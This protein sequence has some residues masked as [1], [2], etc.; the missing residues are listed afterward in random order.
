MIQALYYGAAQ[1]GAPDVFAA[2]EPSLPDDGQGALRPIFRDT[3]IARY[4][5]HYEDAGE[6]ETI[7][8]DVLRRAPNFPLARLVQAE[9][10]LIF[11]DLDQSRKILLELEKDHDLPLWMKEETGWMLDYIKP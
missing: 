7:I 9:V 5:L 8:N 4:K 11:D 2:L 3:L 10:F 6:A 1:E